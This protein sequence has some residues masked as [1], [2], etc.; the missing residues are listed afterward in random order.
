MENPKFKE[1]ERKNKTTTEINLLK[2]P[3][4]IGDIHMKD[5]ETKTTGNKARKSRLF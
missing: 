2:S 1:T 3:C 4:V 5:E